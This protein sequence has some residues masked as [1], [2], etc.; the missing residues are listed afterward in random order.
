M[1]IPILNDYYVKGY[2]P[3][4]SETT[5]PAYLPN[6]NMA[7]RRAVVDDIGGYDEAC[8]AGEDADLS[9]RAARGGWA[10]FYEPR[11]RVYHEPRPD[12]ASLLRQWRWYGDGGARFFAK[13]RTRRLEVYVN[14]NLPPQMHTYRRVIATNWWPVPTVWFISY[15]TLAHL[16]L[17][18]AAV[19][20]A[21][22]WATAAAAVGGACL[23]MLVAMGRRSRLRKLTWRERLLYAGIT[24][25]VNW[26]CT[27]HSIRGGWRQ[28]MLFT[29]PGL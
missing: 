19:L 10:I 24:Y 5:L 7:I 4:G 12:L 11:A 15:F 29:Y 21:A 28:G 8:S 25:L 22:G 20:L 1:M 16:L 17:A 6:V 2:L 23:L 27:V 26:T 9:I 18:I 3:A 14:L 13:Q